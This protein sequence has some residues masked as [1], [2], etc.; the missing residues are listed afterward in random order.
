MHYNARSRSVN[1]ERRSLRRHPLRSTCSFP[2]FSSAIAFR[3]FCPSLHC[4]LGGLQCLGTI[5]WNTSPLHRGICFGILGSGSTDD[6][7]PPPICIVAPS[8]PPA[9]RAALEAPIFQL[10]LEHSRFTLS[11]CPLPFFKLLSP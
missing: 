6:D 8:F 9:Q 7:L 4:M 5:S 2:S 3:L 10:T 11:H 1:L